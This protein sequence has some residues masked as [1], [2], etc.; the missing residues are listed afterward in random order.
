MKP[1][2]HGNRFC[3]FCVSGC[4]VNW[5]THSIDCSLELASKLV[6]TQRE[7]DKAM[8][9]VQVLAVLAA[10]AA[11]VQP[12]P[13]PAQPRIQAGWYTTNLFW[14]GET[15]ALTNVTYACTYVGQVVQAG[16][17]LIAFGGCN[18]NPASCNGYHGTGPPPPPP[19][20]PLQQ[21]QHPSTPPPLGDAQVIILRLL[22]K[23]M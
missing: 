8:R 2:R 20:P 16:D 12:Q 18:A 9:L 14:P 19:P 17:R 7:G 5:L 6:A 10:A 13:E 15:D 22:T 1:K 11:Q 4:H 21:Q 23:Y 3:L